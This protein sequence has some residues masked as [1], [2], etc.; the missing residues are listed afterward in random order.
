MEVVKDYRQRIIVDPDNPIL[1]F[2]ASRDRYTNLPSQE[3]Y[4]GLPYIGSWHSEDALTWNVFR[5]MQ[6][7]KRLELITD[8]LHIGKPR[9]LLLWTLAPEIYEKNAELQYVTGSVIRQFDGKFRG[10]TTEPDIIILGTKGIVVMECKLGERNKALTHLWEGTIGSIKKCLTVYNNEI[11]NLV[12]ER[13]EG[14]IAPVYQLVRMA[15][16]AVKLSDHF[17]VEPVIV[18]L[19]N[20]ENWTIQIRRIKKSPSELWDTFRNRIL[21]GVSLRCESLTWQAIQEL[22]RGG[23]FTRLEEYLMNHPCL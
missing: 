9:G 17:R 23:S 7:A 3:K 18:S 4:A 5:S 11:P 15:F 12:E 2:K 22:A 14:S 19:V 13:D 20:E 21:G 16:Y 8:K 1:A 10:Q 6:K